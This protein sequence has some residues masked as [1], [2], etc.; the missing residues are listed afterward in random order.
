MPLERRPAAPPPPDPV[1]AAWHA[2]ALRGSPPPPDEEPVPWWDASVTRPC[3]GCSAWCCSTLI[4]SRPVPETASQLDFFRYSLGFPG[5]RVGVADDGWAIVVR[6]TCRHLDGGRCSV[7]GTDERP[8]R[9][10]S[11]DQLKCTYRVHFGTPAPEELVLVDLADFPALAAGI[12]FDRQGHIQAIA[13]VDEMRSLVA[14][15]VRDR[16]AS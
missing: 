6:T 14:S 10:S 11:Y 15:G 13:E 2:I 5:V 9:C 16:A 12:A 3:E 4:F 1:E 7:Y 8:L